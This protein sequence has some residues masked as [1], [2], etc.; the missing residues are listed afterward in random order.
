MYW[1]VVLAGGSGPERNDRLW[2]NGK[3][4][5]D[6]GA[7]SQH[8]DIGV[9]TSGIICVAPCRKLVT[10]I[11][12]ADVIIVDTPDD[13]LVCNKEHE[14]DVRAVVRSMKSGDR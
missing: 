7:A 11:G 3:G 9:D 1:A 14:Q 8:G 13:L 12:V 2:R 10:T 4:R 6:R 5:P